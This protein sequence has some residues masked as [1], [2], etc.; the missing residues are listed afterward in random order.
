MVSFRR[1]FLTCSAEP[2]TLL[3]GPVF[4]DDLDIRREFLPIQVLFSPKKGE[5]G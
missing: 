3:L 4:A 1:G 2:S 5:V